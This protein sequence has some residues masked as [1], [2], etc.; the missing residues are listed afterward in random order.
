M[1]HWTL[2]QLLRVRTSFIYA[3]GPCREDLEPKYYRLCVDRLGWVV[4]KLV[5]AARHWPVRNTSRERGLG[6]S[7]ARECLTQGLVQRLF[8]HVDLRHEQ[9]VLLVGERHGRV[10]WVLQ[11][12]PWQGQQAVGRLL[13]ADLG[14]LL[15]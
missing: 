3:V 4:R 9:R 5:G 11:R 7:R 6:P 15:Q 1:H 12:R 10:T 14:R 8:H 13:Y 2:G